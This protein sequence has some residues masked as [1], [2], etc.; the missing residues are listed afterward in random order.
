MTFVSITRLHLASKFSFLPFV[1]YA[2]SSSRQAKRSAGFRG[3]WLSR[4]AES[5][6][7]TVTAWHN[8]EAMRGFRNSGVHMRAMP[9]LLRWCDEAS[10]AHFEHVEEAIPDGAEA[11]ERLRR[12]GKISKVARPSPLQQSG[13]TV[14]K[15]IPP[16]GQ[17]L[18]PTS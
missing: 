1:Y 6:F 12:D 14:G 2:L 8:A 7:W 4:D 18:K 17:I 15:T 5:A 3:G 16:P 10:Y 13:A 9:K 11:Y